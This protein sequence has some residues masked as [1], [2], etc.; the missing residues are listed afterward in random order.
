[1]C[2]KLIGY[3]P[4]YKSNRGNRNQGQQ[5]Q[6]SG[7]SNRDDYNN[8][9]RSSANSIAVQ[10]MFTGNNAGAG[11]QE[12]QVSLGG[13]KMNQEQINKLMSLVN[14]MNTKEGSNESDAT[15]LTGITCFTSISMSRN[16][17]IIDSGA[18]EHITPYA[19]LLHEITEMS[20]PYI[21]VLPDVKRVPVTHSG[22]CIVSRNVALLGVLLVPEIKFNLLSV[23]KLIKDSGGKIT[24]TD[25]GCYIHDQA[26]QTSHWLGRLNGKL[27][28]LRS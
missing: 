26:S 8:N 6:Y 7:Q 28:Q 23:S 17:W 13:I 14:S 22:K 25:K 15:S 1:M 10:S 24:F 16:N 4:G 12:G 3:P 11:P 9:N 18:T 5:Q 20:I 19:D 2:Y 27:F 21:V